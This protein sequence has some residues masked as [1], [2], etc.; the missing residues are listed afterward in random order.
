MG[1]LEQINYPQDIRELPLHALQGLCDELRAFVIEQTSKNP[2]H[3]GASLGTVE[4][5]VALHYV[6]DTPNDKLVWDVGHQAYTHKIITGRKEQ[7]H[8]NRKYKGISGFPKMEES[9]YDAFGTGHS[10]TS[11]SAALGMS[12]ADR[13][14][15]DLARHHVAIIGDG[16]IGGG[17]AFEALNHAGGSN[18]NMLVILND[19]K[20]A[21]DESV[22]AVSKYLLNM[23]SSVRYNKFKDTLWGIFT[24]NKDKENVVTRFFSKIGNAIKGNIVENSNLFQQLGFR[25]FGV[26]DGHDVLTLVRVLQNLKKMNGPK[27]LHIVTVKGKGL[28]LAEKNQVTYHAPGL[29]DP[30]TGEIIKNE[31]NEYPLKYQQVFGKT[32]IELAAENPLVVGISPAMLS[33]CS[34]NMMK[35]VYPDRVF[36]V[37]IAEQHAVTF[38]A[39]LATR[40]YIPVC[41]VYSSFM[42]RAYDQLV[43]D[44]ALQKLPVVFCLDRAGL[45]GEDGATHH[46]NLDLAFL[47]CV[48]NMVVAS[49]MDEQELKDLLYT[50]VQQRKMPFT[51]RYPRGKG[52]MKEATA[53]MKTL[54]IGKSRVLAKGEKVA[55]LSLGPLGNHVKQALKILEKENIQ[56]GHVD[57]RFLKPLDETLILQLSTQY[58]AFVTVEDGVE[59]GGVFSAITE[60]L[61]H[62]F[63]E[64]KVYPIALPDVYVEHGDINALYQ[65]VG[66]DVP[67]ITEKLRKIYSAS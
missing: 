29:F 18:E 6:F 40:G 49:P 26:A 60:L 54:E 37:G 43:H 20:I 44:V 42:Q 57:L 3:L 19:N 53:P 39:G 61:A 52:V 47:R 38:S 41:N 32:M 33:G 4:L 11:I 14:R 34:L 21:I 64:T 58:S 36:D 15:G 67:A 1:W 46:G 22:G 23:T 27:L 24:L 17:M 35:D 56:I 45:V 10:S 50:A 8:T 30:E 66:F 62:H 25:Y 12:V 5:T 59:K 7:F 65:L 55:V 63:I 2:G 16:S 51:L 48:P 9:E 13:L 31:K 28:K